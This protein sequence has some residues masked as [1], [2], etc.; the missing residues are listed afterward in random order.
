MKYELLEF[1]TSTT[2]LNLPTK[3]IKRTLKS[4]PKFLTN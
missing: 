2:F 3:S 4:S 1:S